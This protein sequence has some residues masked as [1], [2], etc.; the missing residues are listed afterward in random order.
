MAKNQIEIT[1]HGF[2][3]LT[4]D[5]LHQMAVLLIKAGY[6]DVG[7]TRN[8]PLKGRSYVYTLKARRSVQEREEKESD[9][10]T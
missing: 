4:Q 9:K 1:P 10:D 5:E 6:I 7:I 3:S 2:G 8:Q